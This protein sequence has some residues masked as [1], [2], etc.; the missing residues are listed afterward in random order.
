MIGLVDLE[1]ETTENLKITCQ[2][3]FGLS[4]SLFPLKRGHVSSHMAAT[5]Y[6]AGR[7]TSPETDN[8]GYLISHFKPQ[9]YE[10]INVV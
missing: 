7:E 8:A 6:K 2:L 10:K 9:N 1:E 4:L 3:A 5:F